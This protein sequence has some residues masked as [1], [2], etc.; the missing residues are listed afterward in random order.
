M[1]RAARAQ[2]FETAAQLRNKLSSLKELQRRIMFGDKEFMDIAKDKALS[3]LV[4]SSLCLRS[5]AD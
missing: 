2:E 3:Q 1:N 4:R 5:R